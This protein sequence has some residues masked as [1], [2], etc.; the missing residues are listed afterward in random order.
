MTKGA[1]PVVLRLAHNFAEIREP[2]ERAV[3][4]YAERNGNEDLAKGYLDY[5][6]TEEAQRLLAG[7]NYRVNDEKVAEEFSDQFPKAELLRVEDVFGIW[8]EAMETHFA[9][10]GELDQLQRR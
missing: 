8:P 7:F 2:I 1:P 5:L 9:S 3:D 6:Y 4:E 10:G